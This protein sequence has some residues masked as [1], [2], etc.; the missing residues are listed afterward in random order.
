MGLGRLVR[1]LNWAR[2]GWSGASDRAYHDAAFQG[3]AYDA[4]DPSYPGWI[5]IRR[6]ADLASSS[7]A[8]ARR[9]VDMGC[10]P[11]EITCALASRHSGCTFVGVDHSATAIER[12]KSLALGAGVSNVSFIVADIEAWIPDA[13]VDVVM[14]FDAFHHVSAPRALI[15]RLGAFTERFFLIEPA[16]TWYGAWR[17]EANLDWIAESIF[18]MRDRLQWQLEDAPGPG[19]ADAAADEIAGEPVERRYPLDEFERF[20]DGYVVD[21]RGTIAGIEKY[22]SRPEAV[23]PLR[24]DIGELTYRLL[25]DIED[26][27][28][29]HDLDLSAKHWAISA[30]KGRGGVRR[31]QR[32]HLG[33]QPVTPTV[34]G[35]YDAVYRVDS[36]PDVVKSG[37]EFAVV[38]SVTNRSW[39][40]WSSHDPARIFLSSRILNQRG[41]VVTADGPRTP[42]P[43]TVQP[44]EECSVYLKVRA[45]NEAGRFR[46]LVDGVH[47]GVAWFSDAG[48]PPLELT[49]KV[50]R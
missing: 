44:G 18:L 42:F 11:G 5:T 3:A 22:G 6:F 1:R 28:V 41:D 15:E 8:G 20:F 10:G 39:R 13:P 23:S 4:T 29:R 17:Q 21:V 47:E 2:R 26:V 48:T 30:Q 50:T 40:E 25:V 33:G 12:A 37:A 14:L 31:R 32:R 35:P 7:L 46:V 34:A 9:A 45:P 38:V 27:L 16:G 19:G 36:V 24:R 49:V 43:R